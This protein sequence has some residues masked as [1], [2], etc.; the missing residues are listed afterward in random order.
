M[1]V[2]KFNI[3]KYAFYAYEYIINGRII[4]NGEVG[5]RRIG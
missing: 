5:R 2:L 1:K 4:D 3:N